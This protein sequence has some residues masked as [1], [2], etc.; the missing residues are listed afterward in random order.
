M[1]GIILAGGSAT[2]LYP[3]T[4][5]ISKHLLPI[6]DKPMIYYPLSVLL[7]GKI[8]DILLISTERDIKRF[9]ELLGDGSN[10]G[11]N[12]EYAIQNKPHGIAEAFLIGKDFIGNEHVVLILGDN[13][14]FGHGLTDLMKDSISTV[15]KEKKSVIWAYTVKNPEHYGVIEI[16]K[17]GIPLSIEEKPKKPKSNWAVVGIYFYPPDVVSKA[18]TLSP[19]ARGE[20]EITDL[21]R[22]YLQENRLEVKLMGRGYAWLDTGTAENLLVAS[23]FVETIEKRTGLKIACLEEIAYRNGFITKKQLIKIANSMKHSA[24]GR[25]LLKIAKEL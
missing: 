21:N 7:L 19:S 13:V 8:R 23:Q 4:R 5:V 20:L 25:Y 14:F 16:D 18:E 6:Y 3:I 10:W 2:R 17:N 24:Y 22:F 1:K 11:I 15:E 9:K 12:I